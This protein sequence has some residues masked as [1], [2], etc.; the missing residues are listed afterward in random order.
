MNQNMLA[1]INLKFI[2]DTLND[3]N[4]KARASTKA[5][6]LYIRTMI[7]HFKHIKPKQE[8]IKEFKVEGNIL[9]FELFGPELKELERLRLIIIEQ[10]GTHYTYI[11]LP[12]WGKYV[13]S[14]RI[15]PEPDPNTRTINKYEKDLLLSIEIIELIC[16][17]ERIGIENAKRLRNIFILEQKAIDKIYNSLQDVKLHF[18]S[19]VKTNLHLITEEPTKIAKGNRY[20]G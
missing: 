17:K 11:F 19:W 1:Y 13:D 10:V 7:N 16:M 4:G 3:T 5:Q 15:K 2:D 9:K 6:I 20:N 8:N 12:V 14:I 18:I